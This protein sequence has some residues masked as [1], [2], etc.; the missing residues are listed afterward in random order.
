MTHFDTTALGFSDMEALGYNADSNTLFIASP[1]ASERYLGE[2]TPTGT[3]LRA[4]DLALM[5]SDGNI[6]SDVAYAPG[7]VNAGIKNIYIASRGVDNNDNRTENDGR[8]WEINIAGSG[9]STPSRTPTAT[10]TGPTA[11]STSTPTF[12][13]TFTA[14]ALP[15]GNTFY[16][17]FGSNGTVGG[18]A[19]A[20][21]DIVQ[22]NGSTWSLFLDGSDVGLGS[23]DLFGFYNL[24]ADSILMSFN[25]SV[26]LG[27]ASYTA[28]DIA[29]FDATS[30][31]STTAGTFSMYFN[32]ADVG[33]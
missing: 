22:F 10:P 6:R 18:V 13:P 24:D 5:G 14:T 26:T 16:G 8:I 15:S 28:N 29:R 9:T 20:D 19:F 30:L 11:T 7:S 32:G 1:R 27:G 25:T 17:S 31:G 4:Y 3:L 2:T 21:E 33:L 12:T 23:V